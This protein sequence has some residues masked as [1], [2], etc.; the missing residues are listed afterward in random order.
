MLGIDNNLY[1]S[2]NKLQ[3]EIPQIKVINSAI[4]KYF[5]YEIKYFYNELYCIG[6]LKQFHKY[7]KKNKK[8]Q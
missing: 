6:S 3:S 7:F 1:T 4:I 8:N 2:C 5:L